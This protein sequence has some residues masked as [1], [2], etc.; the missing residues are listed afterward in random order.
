MRHLP[1]RA[2]FVL[3]LNLVVGCG[4]SVSRGNGGNADLGSGGGNVD[5]DN[6]G[7][8]AD[9]RFDPDAYWAQDPPL[10]Y[11]YL[12]GGVFQPPKTP[13]GTPECPDDKNREGCECPTEGMKAACWPGLRANR[14]L[15][16]CHDGTTTCQK[17]GETLLG[18][19]PC[20]DYELPVPG[21]TS[22]RQACKCFSQGQWKLDNLSPCFYDDGKGGGAGSGGAASTILMNG[23]PQCVQM[24]GSPLVP[25]NMPW[26]NDTITAD[27]AG[28]FKLCYALKGGDAMNAQPNDCTVIKVCTEMDYVNVNQPQSFPPL[29]A[30]AASDPAAVAC[31]KQFATTGGYGEMSVSGQT[32][33]CDKFDRV[34]NRVNYCPLSCN[35]NPNDPKCKNCGNGGGGTF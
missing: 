33:T 22:G 7:P 19:G 10:M 23:A 28:H 32:I 12:D 8:P 31:S 2:L 26:S 30:W 3:S 35:Q 14:G 16:I 24:Q 11:C 34:F 20:M 21:A 29:P 9:L 15:G 6:R 5:L 27:C 25:P 18:W 17:I 13:G 1:L 4:A